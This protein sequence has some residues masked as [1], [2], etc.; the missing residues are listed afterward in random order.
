MKPTKTK[1]KKEIKRLHAFIDKSG[2]QSHEPLEDMIALKFAYVAEA[3][4]RW[5]TEDTEDLAYPLES[6]QVDALI[7]KGAIL[8]RI[9]K[10]ITDL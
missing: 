5:A 10:I 6:A 7:L 4:L 8:D 1:I 3:A 9:G 2:Y